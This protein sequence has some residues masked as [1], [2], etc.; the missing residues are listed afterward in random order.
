[1]LQDKTAGLVFAGSPGHAS[2]VH[3]HIAGARLRRQA[4]AVRLPSDASQREPARGGLSPRVAQRV[5][6][7]IAAKIDSRIENEA[8]AV[9]AGLS[10]CHFGRAFKQSFGLSP[11]QYILRSRIERAK[12]LLGSSELSLSEI[13]IAA[14][15]AD[16]SHL[17]RCFRAWADTTP[18]CYRWSMR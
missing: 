5:R 10:V 15:F 16:H 18:G 14:G 6:D 9:M 12:D 3:D 4:I 11:R 7:Y 2:Q 1:M 8:L 13:A 17:C